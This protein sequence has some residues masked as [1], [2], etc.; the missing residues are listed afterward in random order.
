MIDEMY[1][2][3][4]VD[5]FGGEMIG[6][7]EEGSMYKGIVG[8]MIVS[9]K[10]S[11]PYM[12]KS[13]PEVQIKGE[14]LK[15]EIIKAIELLHSIGFKVRCVVADNHSTNVSAFSKILT[16]NGCDKDDL[17]VI[18]NDGSKVYLFYDSVHLM[19]NIR[20]NLLNNKRFIFP[21]FKFSEFV[22]DISCEAGEI[23]WKL[24][25]DVYEKDQDL[26]SNLKKAPKISARVLHPGNNKQSVPLA[27]SIFHETTSAAIISY[28]P[29]CKAAADF[30]K[31]FDKWW[32]ISN[33]R[34]RYNT[35]N[36]IGNAAELGDKKPKFLR[37]LAD[38]VENWKS[39]A[40]PNCE[41]F[42]LT[43]NTCCVEEN[44]TV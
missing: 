41:R 9:L 37:C 36:R 43:E 28:F 12:I 42:T 33:S 13:L 40:L 32:N 27:L 16:T 17:A 35:N 20:N 18:L 1:L 15:E 30:L 6:C 26:Q 3:K 22:D 19:K 38:W 5:Y 24:F 31:V 34:T 21:A 2:Q 14:W 11:I 39:K 23:S 44:S 8:F 29:E 7:N 10:E 25:H 4:S